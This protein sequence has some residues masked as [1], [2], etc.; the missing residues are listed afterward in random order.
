MGF[1]EDPKTKKIHIYGDYLNTKLH[2]KIW[3][4]NLPIYYYTKPIS[5]MFSEITK[6]GLKVTRIIE[7]KAIP[8]TKKYDKDYWKLNQKIPSFIIFET[9]KT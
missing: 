1:D 6:S 4:N 7:P 8:R 3:I 2:K 5:Q 9:K